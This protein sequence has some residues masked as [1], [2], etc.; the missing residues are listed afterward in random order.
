METLFR[1]SHGV[2]T[3]FMDRME[4]YALGTIFHVPEQL[5]HQ[6]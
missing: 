5:L 2:L 3:Y 6:G 1:E 4:L